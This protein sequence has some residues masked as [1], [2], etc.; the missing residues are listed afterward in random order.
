MGRR[1]VSS[2]VEALSV[3]P[4]VPLRLALRLAGQALCEFADFWENRFLPVFVRI[5]YVHAPFGRYLQPGVSA[6]FRDRAGSESVPSLERCAVDGRIERCVVG[7][8]YSGK[9]VPHVAVLAV[10]AL[11]QAGSKMLHESFY[12]GIGPWVVS[13]GRDLLNS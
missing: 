3:H 8:S 2:L 12:D 10:V 9:I 11:G 6:C 1:L 7:K 13:P 4:L 5:I